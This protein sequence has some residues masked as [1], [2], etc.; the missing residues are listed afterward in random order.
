[1]RCADKSAEKAATRM[2]AAAF[3]TYLASAAADRS[4]AIA[5]EEQAVPVVNSSRGDSTRAT[6]TSAASAASTA[7]CNE[8]E[9]ELELIYSGESDD[10][11]NSQATPH[12]S[13]SPGADTARARLTGSD[14]R[15]GIMSEIFGSSDYSD[16]YPPHASPSIDKARGNGGDAPMHHHERSNSRDRGNTGASAHDGT[17]QEARDQNVLRHAPQAKSPWM[18]PSRELDR[19]AGTT[20]ER[21]RIPLFDCRKICPPISAQKL[22]VLRKSSSPMRSLNIGGTMVAVFGTAKPWCRDGMPS[23]TA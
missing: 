7:N 17:N 8:D 6:D 16:E 9:P 21:D 14:Q 10:A 20:T 12:A 23:S 1:M 13:G 11:S 5:S 2:R 19:L 15:G 22:S 4:P 18:P 3:C